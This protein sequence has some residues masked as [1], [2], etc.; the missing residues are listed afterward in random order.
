MVHK[1]ELH[2]LTITKTLRK[3]LGYLNLSIFVYQAFWLIHMNNL[4]AVTD[5]ISF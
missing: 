3:A 1:H 4:T 5:F 2:E